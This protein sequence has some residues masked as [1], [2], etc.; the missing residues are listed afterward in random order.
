MSN[1]ASL[2]TNPNEYINRDDS[3][4][5]VYSFVSNMFDSDIDI[6]RPSDIPDFGNCFFFIVELQD[7][8]D[9]TIKYDTLS[10]EFDT[11]LHGDFCDDNSCDGYECNEFDG[12]D[13]LRH[14]QNNDDA[15]AEFEVEGGD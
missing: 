6:M 1:M 10:E 14:Y 5:R 2:T 11:Y 15:R 12:E 9:Y 3:F 4:L 13:V 7:G 8:S